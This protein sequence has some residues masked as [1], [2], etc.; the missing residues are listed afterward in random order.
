MKPIPQLLSMKYSFKLGWL[1]LLLT[2]FPFFVQAKVYE[3]LDH[4]PSRDYDFIVV[5]GMVTRSI[6]AYYSC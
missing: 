2:A 4:L 1:S 3:S 5:G 6:L